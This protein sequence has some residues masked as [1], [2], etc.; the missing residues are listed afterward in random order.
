MASVFVHESV[1]NCLMWGLFEAG[2]LRFSIADG[3]LPGLR[4]TA[5]MLAEFMP[6]L[7][8]KYPGL[9]IRL[10]AG[11][12]AMPTITVSEG[13]GMIDGGLSTNKLCATRNRYH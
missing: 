6:E 2:L 9:P 10:E 8:A 3:S 12:T 13:G 1:P 7:A 5:D 4:L 11:V